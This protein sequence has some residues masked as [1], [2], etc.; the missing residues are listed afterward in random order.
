[1]VVLDN[2]DTGEKTSV[3]YF[4]SEADARKFTARRALSDPKVWRS[5]ERAD[6]W[7]VLWRAA[8]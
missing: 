5:R 1:M 3:A 8:A 6:Q 4:A 2:F 7:I